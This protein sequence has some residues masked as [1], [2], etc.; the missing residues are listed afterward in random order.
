[1]TEDYQYLS[2]NQFPMAINSEPS[3]IK[4]L[5]I[6]IRNFLLLCKKK[7]LL[8][9]ITLGCW[10]KREERFND[11]CDFLNNVQTKQKGM[12]NIFTTSF[13]VVAETYKNLHVLFFSLFKWL[14]LGEVAQ[15]A[16]QLPKRFPAISPQLSAMPRQVKGGT[17][18]MT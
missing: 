10:K 16:S 2:S 17:P 1:M 5:L 7:F 9:T 15:N 4:V 13:S 14:R 8:V 3:T 11:H 12:I 6:S 18:K